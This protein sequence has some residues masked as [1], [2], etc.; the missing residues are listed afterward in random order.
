MAKRVYNVTMADG[1]TAEYT[2]KKEVKKLEG[3]AQVTVNGEDI[4]TE[5]VKEDKAMAENTVIETITEDVV[6]EELEAPVEEPKNEYEEAVEAVKAV[7]DAQAEVDA[8]EEP[9]EQNGPKATLLFRASRG[10]SKKFTWQQVVVEPDDELVKV[11]GC[12]AMLPTPVAEALGTDKFV[13]WIDQE[14]AEK[15][16]AESKQVRGLASTFSDVFNRYCKVTETTGADK[17]T[18]VLGIFTD[19]I[20]SIEEGTRTGGWER[21][22]AAPTKEET[23]EDSQGEDAV[24]STAAEDV[25]E[26]IEAA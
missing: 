9:K 20:H 19:I 21:A 6:V 12:A 17:V 18:T 16:V 13:S 15:A 22:E 7:E 10:N 8:V 1:T 3:I 25:V 23:T 24:D 11:K 5:F 4:T 14:Q 2:N 26:N